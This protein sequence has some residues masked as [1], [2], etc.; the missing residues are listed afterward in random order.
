ME[1]DKEYSLQEF[2]ELLDVVSTET[3]QYQDKV[4]END[5]D[6]I[7]QYVENVT[8]AKRIVVDLKNNIGGSKVLQKT[9]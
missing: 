7:N 9:K 2:C 8:Q 5:F 4:S 6:F 3:A 1:F